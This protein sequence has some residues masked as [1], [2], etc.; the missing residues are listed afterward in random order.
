MK[1]TS[2]SPFSAGVETGSKAEN[3]DECSTHAA[4]MSSLRL[5]AAHASQQHA[6]TSHDWTGEGATRRAPMQ[7]TQQTWR[8]RRSPR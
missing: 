7:T 6:D 8:A 5:P 2:H 3:A 1:T 4:R